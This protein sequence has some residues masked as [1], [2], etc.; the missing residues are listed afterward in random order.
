MDIVLVSRSG[1]KRSRH[2]A[3]HGGGMKKGGGASPLV[4]KSPQRRIADARCERS[5]I[6]IHE[7]ISRG[8][9]LGR[10]P[11]IVVRMP[12]MPRPDAASRS[13]EQPDKGIAVVRTRTEADRTARMLHLGD[14]SAPRPTALPQ[15][16]GRR[17]RK[18]RGR[19]ARRRAAVPLHPGVETITRIVCRSDV[20]V[21]RTRSAEVR[22]R[23]VA[24]HHG[25]FFGGC[26]RNAS[27]RA[28][29]HVLAPGLIVPASEERQLVVDA[30]RAAAARRYDERLLVLER[31]TECFENGKTIC[32]RTGFIR[33]PWM[34]A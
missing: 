29:Q 24:R 12:D 20:A 30:Q 28:E 6:A 13:V 27:G 19:Q 18:R 15:H 11:R 10:G 31:R 25:S 26:E 8:A 2:R 23:E 33:S 16:T 9:G 4:V 14:D 22:C 21:G 5:E 34:P 3:R 17:A 32:Y 7:R 1:D